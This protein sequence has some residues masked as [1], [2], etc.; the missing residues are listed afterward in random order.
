MPAT[1]SIGKSTSVWD[2]VVGAFMAA[3][4]DLRATLGAS[5][6]SCGST[7]MNYDIIAAFTHSSHVL[8]SLTME[9]SNR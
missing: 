2:P 9:Q 1:K 7:I 5:T 8:E 4:R 3:L 6:V